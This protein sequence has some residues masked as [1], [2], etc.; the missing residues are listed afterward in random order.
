M[1][2]FYLYFEIIQPMGFIFNIN[3]RNVL[4]TLPFGSTYMFQ[5]RGPK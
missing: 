1:Q 5:V 4:R 3:N 2:A